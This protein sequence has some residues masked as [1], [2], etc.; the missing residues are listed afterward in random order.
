MTRRCL[1]VR[2]LLTIAFFAVLFL[3]P[4]RAFAAKSITLTPNTT[5]VEVGKVLE[6]KVEINT[7]GESVG[8][9]GFGVDFSTENLEGLVPS[10]AGSVFTGPS[11]CSSSTY[12]FVGAPNAGFTGSGLVATLRFKGRVPSTTDISIKNIQVV[13]NGTTRVG[14]TANTVRTGVYASGETPVDPTPTPTD[15]TAPNTVTPNPVNTLTIPEMI[16]STAPSASDTTAKDITREPGQVYG[17]SPQVP[18]KTG[19]D[20]EDPLKQESSEPS[21][22]GLF[23]M[24]SISF[25]SLIPTIL[26]LILAIYLGIKLYFTEKRRHLELERM[27]ENQIGTLSTLESK[28]DL[29]DQK[30]G[31]GKEKFLEEFEN[32]KIKANTIVSAKKQEPVPAKG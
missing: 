2:G 12:C 10:L 24:G 3:F 23:S 26:F 27:F 25:L 7:E 20:P 16:A 9:V 29:L 17:T 31:V 6:V 32:A 22:K 15:P 30:G 21:V 13:F 14:Y 1:K 5:S 11:Y 28:L 18:G 8:T 4:H 19:A